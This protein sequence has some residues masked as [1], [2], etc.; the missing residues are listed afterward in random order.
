MRCDAA[1][2]KAGLHQAI[3]ASE[4]GDDQALRDGAQLVL[5]VPLVHVGEEHGDSST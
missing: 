4:E 5:S 1:G 3:Q 2:G